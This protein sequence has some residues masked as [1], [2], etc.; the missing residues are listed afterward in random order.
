MVKIERPLLSAL[1]LG[2]LIPLLTACGPMY[3]TV[4]TYTPPSNLEGKRCL[5]QCLAMR[6]MCRSNAEGRAAQNRSN[7]QQSAMVN[8]TACISTAKSD[9]ERAKC[10]DSSYACNEQVNTSQCDGDYRVCYSNC[11]GIVDSREVCVSGCQ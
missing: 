2:A 10:T 1:V 11:G 6:E 4:Y 9:S 3:R 8:Y 7:C 5:N